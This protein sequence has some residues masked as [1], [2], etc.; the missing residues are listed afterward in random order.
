[1]VNV[2]ALDTALATSF[3]PLGRPRA[4]EGVFQ[5]QL[6]FYTALFNRVLCLIRP[7]GG[8]LRQDNTKL[9][10]SALTVAFYVIQYLLKMYQKG[11][12]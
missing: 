10:S 1:M 6:F 7:I 8:G 11:R 12:R 9:Q 5:F 2:S 3:F 4:T